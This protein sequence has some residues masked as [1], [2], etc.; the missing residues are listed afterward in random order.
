[1]RSDYFVGYTSVTFVDTFHVLQCCCTIHLLGGVKCT[2]KVAPVLGS[3]LGRVQ[4]R[5]CVMVAAVECS[6]LCVVDN[7]GPS[8]MH[9]TEY[10]LRLCRCLFALHS[11]FGSR[12]C[13][14]GSLQWASRIVGLPL[15]PGWLAFSLSATSG[16]AR[17]CWTHHP[18]PTT[19]HP[20][21]PAPPTAPPTTATTTAPHPM[22]EDVDALTRE[23]PRPFAC[24]GCPADGDDASE[25]PFWD[26]QK[27]ATVAPPLVPFWGPQSGARLG[28]VC[29][30]LVKGGGA[31][32]EPIFVPFLSHEAIKKKNVF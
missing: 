19:H 15:L 23:I 3:A 5:V 32:M 2:P 30:F 9:A 29:L 17:T 24:Q 6:A 10:L 12:D 8:K 7:D 14:C 4:E 22:G 21:P 31:K 20:P 25:G 27:I 18:P 16:A 11:L 13:G 1:M 26:C 28:A